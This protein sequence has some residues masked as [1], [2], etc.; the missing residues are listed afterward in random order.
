MEHMVKIEGLQK[1]GSK[2]ILKIFLLQL[3]AG[4]LQLF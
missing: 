3:E 4:G 1:H 2:Q